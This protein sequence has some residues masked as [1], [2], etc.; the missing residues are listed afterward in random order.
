MKILAGVLIAAAACV[1]QKPEDE[2]VGVLKQMERAEQAGNADAW[3]ALWSHDTPLEIDKMREYIRP[4][5]EVRYTSSRVY[6]QGN[7]AALLGQV[8]AETF[9]HMRFVKED[10]R[11]KIKDEGWSNVALQPDMVYS[12]IPPADGAF[13]RAGSPWQGVAMALDGGVAKQRGWQMRTTFDE[14]FCTFAWNRPSRCR[15]PEAK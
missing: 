9:F 15:R 14:S 6:V 11:W 5:P 1:A 13:M 7:Q 4:R 10:G 12:L 3:V 8:G 2:V